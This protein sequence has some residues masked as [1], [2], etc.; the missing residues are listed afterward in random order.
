M[1]A[2]IK[3][4]LAPPVFEDDED[5]T[6]SASVLNAL[7]IILMVLLIFMV[8]IYVPFISVEK[9]Y[10]LALVLV[11]I[12]A[13][14]VTRWQ[15]RR[16]RVW[17]ASAI[18]VCLMWTVVTVLLFFAGGMTSIAAVFYVSATI[19]AGLMLGTR[20]ALIHAL[21][22]ILAGLAMVI[23][24]SIG[25]SLPRVFPLPPFA[26][27]VDMIVSL[28]LAMIALNL[29][30]RSLKDALELT[31]QQVEERKRAEEVLRE[32]EERY[33]QLF[34]A[35]S[36]A[37]FLIEN[38]GG[39]I[40]EV[41]GAASALYGYSREELLA[42]RNEDLS[43]EPED[44]QK[45]TRETP[46]VIDQVVTIPL[47]FHRKK[48]GTVFPVEITGRFF[49][50]QGRSV[51]I[52][53]IRDIT[54][55]KRAEEAL[56]ESEER[57]RA[58][59][60]NSLLGVGISRENQV[61]FAN[62]ALLR[63]FG[64]N[65]LE[66]FARVPLLDHVAPA[67]KE[68]VSERSE[69]MAQDEPVPVEFE[70][71]IVRK[72]GQ[73]R[74]L[75]AATSIVT[76]DDENYRHTTFQDI[77]KRKRAEESLR[78]SEE[79]FSKA[80]HSSPL[81]V[82]ITRPPDGQFIEVNQTF[83]ILC[84]YSRD[85]V[86]G[87]TSLDLGLI[88]LKDREKGQRTLQER[89]SFRNLEVRFYTKSGEERIGL[90]SGDII[91]I[92]GE[93]RLMQ[94]VS[95]IT[96]RKQAEEALRESHRRLEETLAE[97][98]ETQE[99][100]LHQERLAAVG[101]LAA[102]IA[103]DFNNILATIVL[104]TQM[105]LRAADLSPQIRKRLETITGQTDRAAD[106]VQQILDFGRRSVLER[107]PL[108][109]DSFLKEV[110]KLLQRTL[111]ESIQIDLAFEPAPRRPP[112]QSR[113]VAEGP[114]EYLINADITRIQQVIVNLALNARDAM[115]NGG[116]LHIA[117]SRTAGRD[118]Q[119]VD[120]GPVIGGEWIEVTVT[121]TGTGIAPDVLPHIFEPFFTTRA[122]LGHGLGLS[123]VYGIIKQH[124]GHIDVQ[125]QV[126]Q[127]TTFRLY[128]PVLAMARSQDEVG[129]SPGIMQGQGEII[130]VVEDDTT[131]R[132]VLADALEGL[133]YQTLAAGNGRE[134]LAI[135]EQHVDQVSLILS[136]WVMPSMGGLELVRELTTHHTVP[137]VLMLTGHPLA[138]EVKKAVPPNVVGWIL[139]PLSLDQL[140]EAVSRALAEI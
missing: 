68:L 83:E 107:R 2:R 41:N 13:L 46:A 95:D 121:D 102:G 123:Q 31:R 16:G 74:T 55:R 24:E 139:K 51:H 61:I 15:M 98:K 11:L 120:C 39:R 129:E 63:I 125:T 32:S 93:V 25:R 75:Q 100:M 99:Q 140:A 73:I 80:F 17:L 104:Y 64:Y 21:A 70:Y 89:G 124:E 35:E 87:L 78:E 4:W 14:A 18:W 8:S 30:L 109:L 91:E 22:C 10:S 54:E 50:W 111:P 116:E 101:Q 3:K 69:K 108:A 56:R 47:R 82:A 130:L 105:S 131:M 58:L 92:R 94:V 48:D 119:C 34:E 84:G 134:A 26:G 122:P 29:V 117:L 81:A 44:T 110:V 6:R 138:E 137:K 57:Y 23:L 40:L 79:K 118:I 114:V 19:I 52:A 60:E 49:V 126:G 45:V 27:W 65:T 96:E 9:L 88:N 132:T 42:K 90:F 127:G 62:P 43:A 135:Y 67:S 133:G 103:H 66:E 53:A 71:D 77:T 5:K 106:L 38:D 97:L 115:P 128:W 1:L 59:V 113:G 76:L 85:E 7:L 12:F 112:S 72:D 37:I 136:D 20:A 86:I 33:R 28:S 36:D